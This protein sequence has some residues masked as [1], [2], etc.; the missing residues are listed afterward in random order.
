MMD[1]KDLCFSY[2]GVCA[3]LSVNG[4]GFGGTAD[5]EIKLR[6]P[7]AR[8]TAPDLAVKWNFGGMNVFG[9][10]VSLSLPYFERMTVGGVPAYDRSDCFIHPRYGVIQS[11]TAGNPARC[12]PRADYGGSR[13]EYL[14]ETDAFRETLRDGTIIWYEEKAAGQSGTGFAY[15]PTKQ[16]DPRGMT[17][18][19]HYR[20]TGEIASIEYRDIPGGGYAFVIDFSY[21]PRPDGEISFRGGFPY[22]RRLRCSVITVSSVFAEKRKMR[23]IAFAYDN[24]TGYSLLNRITETAFSGGEKEAAPSICIS[25]GEMGEA[26]FTD[27]TSSFA[28]VDI[29]AAVPVSL[30]REGASG[31]FVKHSSGASYSPPVGADGP[32]PRFGPEVSLARLPGS[33]SGNTPGV[34]ARRAAGGFFDLDGDGEIQ[35]LAPGGDGYYEIR[36]GQFGPFTPFESICPAGAAAE[37]ADL[38]GDGRQSAFTVLSTGEGAGCEICRGLGKKGFGRPRTVRL[39]KGFPAISP[40]KTE[41]IGFARFFGDGLQHR[42]ALRDKSCVVFPNLGNGQFGEGIRVGNA[43]DFGGEFDAERVRFADT[44]GSGTDDIIY[45]GRRQV[46]VYQNIAGAFFEAPVAAELPEPFAPSD[47][48]YAADF[49]GDLLP[50]LIFIKRASSGTRVYSLR[51]AHRFLINGLENGLGLDVKIEYESSAQF[52]LKDAASGC[53]WGSAPPLHIPV[54]TG[55]ISLDG[56]T[57]ERGE[58]HYSYRDGRY[59]RSSRALYGFGS[60]CETRAAA[61]PLP[62]HVPG[63]LQPPVCRVTNEYYICGSEESPADELALIGLPLTTSFA[64]EDGAVRLRH[65]RTYRAE[66]LKGAPDGSYFPA[67]VEEETALCGGDPR[68]SRTYMAYDDDGNMTV[69]ETHFLPLK[70]AGA[71]AGQ[72]EEYISKKMWEYIHVDTKDT[73]I[74]SIIFKYTHYTGKSSGSLTLASQRE[75][76]YADPASGQALA[77]GVCA[78]PALPHHNRDMVCS[79]AEPDLAGLEDVLLSDCGCCLENGCYYISNEACGY[80]A[81]HFFRLCSLTLGSRVTSLSYDDSG[82]FVTGIEQSSPDGVS[83]AETYTPDYASCA[84]QSKTDWNGNTE[85]YLYDGFGELRGLSYRAAMTPV[86]GPRSLAEF[87]SRPQDWLAG[88]ADAYIYHD[89]NAWENA[90]AAACRAAAVRKEMQECKS[91]SAC[92]ELTLSVSYTDGHG[93]GYGQAVRDTDQWIISD[94]A[95]YA[96]EMKLLEYPPCHSGDPAGGP[97]GYPTAYRYD[98]FGRVVKVY[99][100]YSEPSPVWRGVETEYEPWYVRTTDARLAPDAEGISRTIRFRQDLDPRGLAITDV[101]EEPCGPADAAGGDTAD[102]DVTGKDAAGADTA[103]RD[104]AGK[105]A[106]VRDTAVRDILRAQIERDSS[107]NAASLSD[108]R[109]AAAGFHNL[110]YR[111]DRLGRVIKTCSADAGEKLKLYGPEGRLMYEDSNGTVKRYSYDALGRFISLSVQAGQAKPVTAER[112]VWGE[113]APEAEARNLKGRVWQRTDRSGTTVCAGYDRFGRELDVERHYANGGEV[114]ARYSYNLAGEL[115]TAETGPFSLTYSYSPA[116]RLMAVSTAEGER[117]S[118]FGYNAQGN[119]CDETCPGGLHAFQSYDPVTRFLAARSARY[120]GALLHKAEYHFTEQGNLAAAAYETL[121]RAPLAGAY[122]Y[123]AHSRLI[124]ARMSQ[125]AF[126]ADESHAGRLHSNETSVRETLA[127]NMHEDKLYTDLSYVDETYEYDGSGNMISFTRTGNLLPSVTR[128]FEIAADSNRIEAAVING[129]RCVFSYHA[130]GGPERLANGQSASYDEFGRLSAVTGGE[131][132]EE[133]VYDARGKRAV[134]TDSAGTRTVYFTGNPLAGDYTRQS[135][136]C[137]ML[138]LSFGGMLNTVLLKSDTEAE[139]LRQAT[140][141]RGSVILTLDRGG[142]ILLQEAFSPYGEAIAD[143]N[144]GMQETPPPALY[145]FAGREY[146]R[147]TGL[148]YLGARYYSPEDGR[149][150][151]PDDAAYAF[152]GGLSGLNLYAYCLDNP[153]TFEDVSGNFPSWIRAAGH[154]LSSVCTVSGAVGSAVTA[155]LGVS[156][157]WYFDAI[158]PF[159]VT[160]VAA[161]SGAAGAFISAGGSVGD[162]LISAAVTGAEAG[163][164]TAAINYGKEALFRRFPGLAREHPAAAGYA[165]TGINAAAFVFTGNVPGGM[166]AP[167]VIAALGGG[168]LGVVSALYAGETGML[169]NPRTEGGA[170]RVVNQATHYHPEAVPLLPSGKYDMGRIAQYGVVDFSFYRNSGGWFRAAQGAANNYTEHRVIEYNASEASQWSAPQDMADMMELCYYDSHHTMQ[171]ATADLTIIVHGSPGGHV[172]IDGDAPLAGNVPVSH[173]F[174]HAETLAND[175]AQRIGMKPLP[176]GSLIKLINCHGGE[177]RPIVGTTAQRIADRTGMRVAAYDG[178]VSIRATLPYQTNTRIAGMFYPH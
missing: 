110:S 51:F 130:H 54:V 7:D 82:I 59:I 66:R 129:Q 2:S 118:S 162:R 169:T 38:Y 115:K 144:G 131:I 76:Y 148:C 10:G 103:D 40:L 120:G 47:I 107:G 96:G 33:F 163:L 18:R 158:E 126:Q 73:H 15:F 177:Y 72:C 42:I 32:A 30:C 139:T 6:V 104:V 106:A 164:Y 52:K 133:Y 157:G 79:A 22:A 64:G 121:G 92:P 48:V 37:F 9:R 173:T 137:E 150:I 151:T 16:A 94:K 68:I 78:F 117:L 14:P 53:P 21:E 45:I 89:R 3:E 80:D 165:V 105:D 135:G 50:Q 63:D 1:W 108:G 8:G 95:I 77:A 146:D 113:G 99:T 149:M 49:T 69:S 71:L 128:S 35:W 112:I 102:R 98:L 176:P 41:Y 136:G 90:R 86:P 83:L 20:D 27:I 67:L 88:S 122:A 4:P 175:I 178:A 85:Y 171:F 61:V 91:A 81:D 23:E 29:G 166:T 111:Y 147:A 93:R 125:G 155:A 168:E 28:G 109:L 75:Y 55:I 170:I 101:Y 123:D 143:E 116:G 26:A 159:R 174:V 24:T 62:E 31:L 152:P 134:K 119:V 156:L 36:D 44:T 5:T 124:H 39:P 12:Y 172:F 58:A 153:E 114:R 160:A 140:D 161:F 70:S 167:K 19:F 127:E 17:I 87:L 56:V 60:V 11:G 100:P 34:T 97:D 132:S 138:K 142:N 84:Y 74:K 141:Q 145:R 154:F 25:Y 57:G 65:T 13:I 43:P 46:M